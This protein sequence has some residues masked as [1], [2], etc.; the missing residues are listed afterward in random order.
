MCLSP[1]RSD[2]ATA[3]KGYARQCPMRKRTAHGRDSHI[4]VM[5]VTTWVALSDIGPPVLRWQ[6]LLGPAVAVLLSFG[7]AVA[8]PALGD[9]PLQPT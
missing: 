7:G 8:E 2:A 9:A 4:V 6:S 1:Q 5:V 3:A